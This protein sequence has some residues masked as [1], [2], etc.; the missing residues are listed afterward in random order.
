[1][2][3]GAPEAR[4]FHDTYQLEQRLGAGG[5][6]EV[7]VATHLRLNRRVAIKLL[8]K[9]RWDDPDAWSRFRREAEIASQLGHPNIVQVTDFNHTPAGEP[10][11]VM[12]LLEGEDLASRMKRG[13]IPVAQALR[14]FEQLASAL[15]AV[16]DK[17]VV[18]RDFKPHNVF[19]CDHG[20]DEPFPKVLDFGV[21][22][23]MGS[24][25]VVTA[26]RALVG[27]PSYMAPEQAEGESRNVDAR[28]DQ[29]ALATMLYE[30]L[31][32]TN[33]FTADSLMKSL[34]RVVNHDPSPLSELLPDLPA[35]IAPAVTRAM[36]KSRD[37]RFPSIRAFARAVMGKGELAVK[38]PAATTAALAA[39]LPASG[40]AMALSTFSG[41]V[42]ELALPTLVPRS[43]RWWMAGALAVA[44]IALALLLV[45]RGQSNEPPGKAKR[46][47]D[48]ER[49]ASSTQTPGTTPAPAAAAPVRIRFEVTPSADEIAIDGQPITGTRIELPR[50][51][52]ERVARF[53]KRGYRTESR[54]FSP[55]ATTTLRVVLTPLPP[56]GDSA[57]TRRHVTRRRKRA[58]RSE[59]K[60]AATTAPTPTNPTTEPPETKKPGDF[61]TDFK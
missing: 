42:G 54:R 52:A 15:A 16:H 33:P 10:Y 41:S 59:T 43:R 40:E 50:G 25:S 9:D 19:L 5:M 13:P 35:H 7:Y 3:M 48:R 30:M 55:A 34:Y 53:S 14:L 18:H 51:D 24:A 20:D 36:A 23:I 27:T 57:P 1:M 17:D 26:D 45:W 22:K 6:G 37:D 61:I 47:D 44:A 8:N 21:S 58:R 28:A 2:G 29:F 12:E 4:V 56:D 39:T 49:R 46:D 60:P 31:S 11:I 38:Q 32:G